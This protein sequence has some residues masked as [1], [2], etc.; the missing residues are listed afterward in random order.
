M[1]PIMSVMGRPSYNY[2][3]APSK[4]SIFIPSFPREIIF[5]FFHALLESI[6]RMLL[7]KCSEGIECAQQ[8]NPK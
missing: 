8:R 6:S 5:G 3:D 2:E 1:W 4:P 7:I